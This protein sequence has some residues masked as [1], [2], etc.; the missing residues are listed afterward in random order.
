MAVNKVRILPDKNGNETTF[1]HGRDVYHTSE[2]VI[3]CEGT[4]VNSAVLQYWCDAG[5]AEDM[6]GDYPTGNPGATDV[7]LLVS[8]LDQSSQAE[9]ING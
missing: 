6:T 3:A 1:K 4:E 9:T 2:V 5:W 7:V 8:S